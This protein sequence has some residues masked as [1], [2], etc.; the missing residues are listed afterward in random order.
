MIRPRVLIPAVRRS[1]VGW[2]DLDLALRSMYHYC[3]DW[4]VI[5]SHRGIPAPTDVPG[6]L[7]AGAA[8]IRQPEGCDN[9]GKACRHLLDSCEDE[10]LLIV[11]DDV[12]FTPDFARLLDDDVRELDRVDSGWGLVGFRSN[13]AAG[14]GNIRNPNGEP[15]LTALGFA[16]EQHVLQ[17][18]FVSGFAFLT[19]RSALAAIPDD[20]LALHWY[21]DNLLCHDLTRNGFGVY[22]SRAYLHH[23]GSRASGGTA[24][25]NRYNA[26]GRAWLRAHRPDFPL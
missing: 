21:S 19:K 16:S 13:F 18:E 7:S 14:P 26:E 12:V 20:W 8:V 3:P 5:V 23:H 22:L 4:P 17:V 11:N 25:W 1:D 2:A 9:F 10:L 6:V 15:R 24:N